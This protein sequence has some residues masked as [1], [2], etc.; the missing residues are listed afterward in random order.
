MDG[1]T[2][3]D[4]FTDCVSHAPVLVTSESVVLPPLEVNNLEWKH[5]NDVHY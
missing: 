4:G 1:E 3:E 2:A 5:C